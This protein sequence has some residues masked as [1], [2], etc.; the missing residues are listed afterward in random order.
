[1]T[2]TKRDEVI[3]HVNQSLNSRAR[4]ESTIPQHLVW[5]SPA[6]AQGLGTKQKKWFGT[7]Q[8]KVPSN[9][10]NNGIP[11]RNSHLV[12]NPAFHVAEAESFILG[13]LIICRIATAK[14]SQPW[15]KAM[16]TTGQ[17]QKVLFSSIS[18]RVCK[19][20]FDY[21]VSAWVSLELYVPGN[22][23][24]TQVDFRELFFLFHLAAFGSAFCPKTLHRKPPQKRSY[25]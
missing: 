25:N 24:H 22:Y 11:Q 20:K 6:R 8:R 15:E 16:E 9:L 14:D 21:F 19:P 3:Y 17:T 2:V 5:T 10:N 4:L 1:M 13:L 18:E 7:L 12:L 23:I